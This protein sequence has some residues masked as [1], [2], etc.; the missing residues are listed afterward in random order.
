MSWR[1]GRG[2]G[3]GLEEAGRGKQGKNEPKECEREGG[4][5][6]EGRGGEGRE[7]RGGEGRGGEGRG[8]EGRE[9]RALTTMARLPVYGSMHLCIHNVIMSL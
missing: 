2:G 5:G 6:G 4:R 9:G 3:G 7:G 1:R 8:G